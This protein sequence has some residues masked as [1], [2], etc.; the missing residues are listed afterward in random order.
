MAIRSGPWKLVLKGKDS[1][2]LYHLGDDLSESTNLA[3]SYS[4][5]VKELTGLLQEANN[6]GRSN[7]GPA[8]E[9]EYDITLGPGAN[10]TRK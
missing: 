2:E 1:S 8:Q 9:S 7:P 10:K 4:D 5:K 6:N 3:Q